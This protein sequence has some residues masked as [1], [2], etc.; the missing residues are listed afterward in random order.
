MKLSKTEI[1]SL[2]RTIR[3][4]EVKLYNEALDKARE[5]TKVKLTA[6]QVTEVKKAISVLSKIKGQLNQNN[7]YIHSM[8]ILGHTLHPDNTKTQTDK[9]IKSIENAL[10]TRKY[11]DYIANNPLPNKDSARFGVNS[12]VNEIMDELIIMTI[13]TKDIKDLSKEIL[14]RFNV[15]LD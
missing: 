2:A 13:D 3:A 9:I 5:K 11:N 15:P 4:K 1:L 7:Q 10:S 12:R 6:T 14:K 8:T